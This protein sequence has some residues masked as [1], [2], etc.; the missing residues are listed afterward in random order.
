RAINS[1]IFR[2]AVFYV[3]SIVLLSLLLPYTAYS[4]DQSPFV[5][6]FSSLG[7]P[8]VG[9]IAGSVMNFVV[10]TAAMSSL[11][12]GLYS[13]GRVLHSMGMNGSAPKF[14]TVMSK[15]GVPFGG[16]MLTG[17]ITLLGVGLNAL[18]PKQAF[19]IVLNV[20]ALGI[21]AGWGTIILCQMR[22]RTW[23]KQGKAKEPT[24]RLPGAPVTSWLT[25]A[26]LV[27][28]LVL[29]AIDWPIGTLTVASLV[30]IIPLLVVGWYLQRDR[31][32]EI[33]R[34]R[35]GITGPFPVTGRDAADQRKR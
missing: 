20:A 23:A 12:A 8:Q 30:V 6:F 13:T 27:S 26:F 21:V 1:V 35:E 2:I 11:N 34:L 4:A 28:V 19:E 7:S 31:I 15:G 5:T 9:A 22:L 3:G 10:L 25:L 24:F 33:A 29:M 16:I 17:S 18:V 32:L 14:T